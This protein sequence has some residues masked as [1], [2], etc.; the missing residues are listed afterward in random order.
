M[1]EGDEVAV[2]GVRVR[3]GAGATVDDV[4]AL[5]TWLER[6]EPLE[7]LLSKRHLIIEEQAGTDGPDGRLGPDI[8]LVLRVLGHVVTLAA[9][10]E[11]TARA[12]KAWTNN[13]RR[14]QRGDPDPEIRPL[15]PDGE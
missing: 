6:E 10:T 8:E 15:D 12:V 1:T 4:R 7:E 13:R 5:K 2:L 3:L 9:L 11:Y 14:L